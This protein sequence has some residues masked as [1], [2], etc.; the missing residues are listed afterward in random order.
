MLEEKS[1]AQPNGKGKKRKKKAK[2][3]TGISTEGLGNI[4]GEPER[5]ARADDP[6]TPEGHD[7][8]LGT[9]DRNFVIDP[10]RR[11]GKE[12]PETTISFLP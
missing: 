2:R 7:S 3:R 6:Q 8:G 10:G 9:A 1:R 11:S 12:P 5:S 4:R